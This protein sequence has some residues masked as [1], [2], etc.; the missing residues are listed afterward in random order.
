M[1]T[2]KQ[3]YHALS[4]EVQEALNNDGSRFIGSVEQDGS[5]IDLYE[6]PDSFYAVTLHPD[7]RVGL[8][9]TEG[10]TSEEAICFVLA[11]RDSTFV[12]AKGKWDS[13]LLVA[14]DAILV[15]KPTP[16]RRSTRPGKSKR[17]KPSA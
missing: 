12:P 3:P 8:L 16:K 4:P 14:P 13:H 9:C 10:E 5:H 17:G 6:S 2:P 1:T 15:P 11:D 7:E